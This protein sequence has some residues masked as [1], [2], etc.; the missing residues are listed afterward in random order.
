MVVCPC[1]GAIYMYMTIIFKQLLSETAWPINAKFH[2]AP[3]W[4]GR[5]NIS[6]N[7]PGHMTKIADMPIYGKNIQKSSPT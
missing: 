7:G 2:V 6:I 5:N 3:S 4:E 1:P